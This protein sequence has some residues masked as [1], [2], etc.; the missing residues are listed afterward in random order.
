MKILKGTVNDPCWQYPDVPDYLR[1]IPVNEDDT[2]TIASLGFGVPNP[3]HPYSQ[4]LQRQISLITRDKEADYFLFDQAQRPI[5]FALPGGIMKMYFRTMRGEALCTVE[6]DGVRVI[7]QFLVK[8]MANYPGLSRERI[9][10]QLSTEYGCDVAKQVADMEKEMAGSGSQPGITYLE[11]QSRML[12]VVS[13][14][15]L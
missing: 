3:P 15:I 2:V 1:D 7:T 10:G 5:R 8:T 4:A 11:E 13:R 6:R 12:Q 9:L 14:K